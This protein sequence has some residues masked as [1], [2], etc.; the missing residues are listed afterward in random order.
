MSDLFFKQDCKSG[1]IKSQI[2]TR[3]IFDSHSILICKNLPLNSSDKKQYGSSV[4]PLKL[5]IF[6]S[7]SYEHTHEKSV[8]L[9]VEPGKRE[10]QNLTFRLISLK[11]ESC[12][13]ILP[14][15]STPEFAGLKLERIMLIN[16]ILTACNLQLSNL[17]TPDP[18]ALRLAYPG[19][20]LTN[21]TFPN[22]KLFKLK[23]FGNY[24]IVPLSKTENGTQ[25]LPNHDNVFLK[26]RSL[27]FKRSSLPAIKETI[28][29]KV[30]HFT[31]SQVHFPIPFLP[32][33]SLSRKNNSEAPGNSDLEKTGK[34]IRDTSF[35]SPVHFRI[36]NF[37]E[38]NALFLYR[39]SSTDPESTGMGLSI[40]NEQKTGEF[41]FYKKREIQP[42]LA[43][44]MF[45]VE[46]EIAGKKTPE[47]LSKNLL[48]F[49]KVFLQG[50]MPGFPEF[51]SR[52][53]LRSFTLIGSPLSFS[54]NENL[55]AVAEKH[56]S[57]STLWD[58]NSKK[59][60]G[61]KR[62]EKIFTTY[63][64][65]AF[66]QYPKAND[67][68][69]AGVY[70]RILIPPIEKQ[71]EN[72]QFVLKLNPLRNAETKNSGHTVTRALNWLTA[73]TKNI[74]TVSQFNQHFSHTSNSI[75][76]LQLN[77]QETHELESKVLAPDSNAE[78]K[79][80][81]RTS[82]PVFN[83]L[84]SLLAINKWTHTIGKYTID[85]PENI[86]KEN[87]Y[88]YLHVLFQEAFKLP[89]VPIFFNTAA[90]EDENPDH[91][92]KIPVILEYNN[93]A[94]H[95]SEQL[96][97][98]A[99]GF[100]TAKIFEKLVAF[101]FINRIHNLKRKAINNHTTDNYIQGNTRN[102]STILNN[103]H[104]EKINHLEKRAGLVLSSLLFLSP[105][106]RTT[107]L[108][109][110]K[111]MLNY[112][113]SRF[114]PS[115][116]NTP[117]AT[118]YF[119]TLSKTQNPIIG[120]RISPNGFLPGKLFDFSVTLLSGTAGTAAGKKVIPLRLSKFASFII[121]QDPV[122][123][124]KHGAPSNIE[125]GILNTG[126]LEQNTTSFSHL[127]EKQKPDGQKVPYLNTIR[128]S[129]CCGGGKK[130]NS[131]MGNFLQRSLL[132]FP[133]EKSNQQV[134][135]NMYTPAESY[136]L[137]GISSGFVRLAKPDLTLGTKWKKAFSALAPKKK[138]EERKDMFGRFLLEFKSFRSSDNIAKSHLY[139]MPH[140]TDFVFL[141]TGGT[142]KTSGVVAFGASGK[143]S[144][145]LLHAMKS[146]HKTGRE[147]LVYETSQNLQ[148]EIEKIEKV[149]FET[150]EAVEDHF[151]SHLQQE[152]RKTG[153]VMDIE[154]ISEKVMRIINH[155]LK[156]EV[157]RRGI[158]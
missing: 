25:V 49:K 73:S 34:V 154:H 53:A 105:R 32:A 110:K 112:F 26:E 123:A 91:L 66:Q 81:S 115:G 80:A 3:T 50:D 82:I 102:F 78:I 12:N 71:T 131:S 135:K 148:E 130:E 46:K 13:F 40:I 55:N 98:Q 67:E 8:Y 11:L 45:S 31:G 100:T 22:L 30:E 57:A 116:I 23:F 89:E 52:P 103:N 124:R 28:V 133:G 37:L 149:A 136:T 47:R 101:S 126:S 70:E 43:G 75:K 155:R 56:E 141:R 132:N 33:S 128:I 10:P 121:S 129:L 137:Q 76:V 144:S 158:F 85:S 109:P 72:L 14:E 20:P 64:T 151:E 107:T 147:E 35:F 39:E 62:S 142:G 15:Q 99:S 97:D 17:R 19:C 156:I 104:L 16:N 127:H 69:R 79:P 87:N 9:N 44:K 125:I 84:R 138:L 108:L 140:S 18:A 7:K 6:G 54:K 139:F 96:A 29:Q 42:L 118:E 157:E 24:G 4:F 95:T 77:Q 59:F 113:K 1:P 88:S 38:K 65:N 51:Y 111:D 5:N 41:R 63:F 120:S 143:E 90:D 94:T 153:Q 83:S 86:I 106:K 92:R 21:F 61:Y 145:E 134:N 93:T 74:V 48:T 152:N 2:F 114:S 60:S 146:M 27:F 117:A 119:T 122:F 58:H 68:I 36:R 150:K